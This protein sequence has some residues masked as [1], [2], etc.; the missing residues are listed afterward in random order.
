MIVTNYH[1]YYGLTQKKI[2]KKLYKKTEINKRAKLRNHQFSI[3]ERIVVFSIDK[4]DLQRSF[5]KFLKNI[6]TLER[7]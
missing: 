5:P 4:S 2:L 1:Q 6:G 3:F 7:I